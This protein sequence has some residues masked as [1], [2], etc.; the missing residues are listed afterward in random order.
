MNTGSTSTDAVGLRERLGLLL[1]ERALADIEG[2][3]HNAA[4]AADLDGDIDATR[5]AWVGAAVTEIATLRGQLSG[6][7]QG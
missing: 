4:Y 5:S 6:R 1:A 2:L 7:Q 3:T